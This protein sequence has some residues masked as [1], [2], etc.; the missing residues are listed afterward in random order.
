MARLYMAAGGGGDALAAS[1][2]HRALGA[3]EPA[4]IATYAW[5]RLVVD[6]LPGPRTPSDFDGL[7]AVGSSTHAV[8]ATTR[9][10][11]PAASTLPRLAGDLADTLALLDPTGGA[12][13]MRRQV[14]EL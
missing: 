4:F 12:V 1:I 5:D 3:R 7:E 8:V 2:L 9:P 11:P 13:G 10:R 6:P 14:D